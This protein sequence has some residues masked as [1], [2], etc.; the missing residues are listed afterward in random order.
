[1]LREGTTLVE[2]RA[3]TPG[4][5]DELG[6]A[7]A[8]PPPALYVQ[9]GAFSDQANAQRLLARLQ[10]AGLSSSFVL[11]PASGR[12]TLYRVRLGPVSSVAD[13]DQLAARLAALGIPDARLAS[14]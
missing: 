13:Y 14:D 3:L 2:V 8:A 9:A 5:P 4:V 7:A 11:S 6:R 10:A 1:M 12:S